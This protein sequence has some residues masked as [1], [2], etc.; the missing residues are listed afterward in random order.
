MQ[1]WITSTLNETNQLTRFIVY[2]YIL[3][4]CVLVPAPQTNVSISRV[5][6]HEPFKKLKKELNRTLEE[7]IT[8]NS[9]KRTRPLVNVTLQVVVTRQLTKVFI[10]TW[11]CP[12]QTDH[13]PL[14]VTTTSAHFLLLYNNIDVSIYHSTRTNTQPVTR[15]HRNQCVPKL[16]GYAISGTMNWN[17]ILMV[18]RSETQDAENNPSYLPRTITTQ[19]FIYLVILSNGQRPDTVTMPAHYSIIP[20]SLNLMDE[21]I[22]FYW[23]SLPKYH[24]SVPLRSMRRR[25]AKHALVHKIAPLK[26]SHRRFQLRGFH[27]PTMFMLHIDKRHFQMYAFAYHLA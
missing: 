4:S 3:Y 5:T 17:S 11:L 24:P 22:K 25:N 21:L 2:S 18:G 6:P 14:P 10:G 7:K 15:P 8:R 12:L 1:F 19:P 23:N 26:P 13:P 27:H 9:I 20:T 16:N